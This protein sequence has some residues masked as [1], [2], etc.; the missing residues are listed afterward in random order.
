[1]DALKSQFCLT[2]PP[3]SQSRYCLPEGSDFGE[4][5]L[6]EDKQRLMAMSWFAKL[7]LL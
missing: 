3:R 7:R 2:C 1:M 6:P 4:L 5:M